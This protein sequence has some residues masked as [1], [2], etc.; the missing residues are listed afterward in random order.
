[1]RANEWADCPIAQEARAR[2]VIVTPGPRLPARSQ[3]P[4]LIFELR[5]S[6][7]IQCRAI[8]TSQ[9]VCVAQR[10]IFARSSKLCLG[11]GV[12]LQFPITTWSML[13]GSTIWLDE[14]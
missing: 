9:T 14:L 8:Y 10:E 6:L 1:M 4:R 11:F 7:S 2:Q 5:K 12:A 3:F 13:D